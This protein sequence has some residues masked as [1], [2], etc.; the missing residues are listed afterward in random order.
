MHRSSQRTKTKDNPPSQNLKKGKKSTNPEAK[1]QKIK[2]PIHTKRK[3]P[4]Y[5]EKRQQH[6]A[7]VAQP[8]NPQTKRE[9]PR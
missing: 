8:T 6:H 5:L 4:H 1:I 2:N 7:Q 3:L 9:T